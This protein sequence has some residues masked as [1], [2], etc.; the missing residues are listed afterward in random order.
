MTRARNTWTPT[1]PMNSARVLHTVT[2]LPNG[3]VLAAGGTAAAFNPIQQG[4]AELYDPA[5]NA[6]TV[7]GELVTPRA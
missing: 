1:S 2:L 4:S 5:T 7:T 3:K 6:W